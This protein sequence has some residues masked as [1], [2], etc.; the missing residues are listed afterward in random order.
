WIY[1][2]G[3]VE[4]REDEAE[5]GVRLVARLDAQALG[6]FERQFPDVWVMATGD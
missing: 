2:N 5:G 4:T 3:R 6:R 1:R